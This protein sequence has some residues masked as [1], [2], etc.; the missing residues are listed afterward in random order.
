MTIKEQLAEKKSAFVEME[1]LLKAE[2]VSEETI[3][4]GEALHLR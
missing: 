1:A 4:Q 3:A 2:D